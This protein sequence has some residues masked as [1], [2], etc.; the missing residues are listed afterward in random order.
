MPF[1]PGISFMNFSTS[2]NS[3]PD[4]VLTNANVIALDP[5]IPEADW[6]AIKGRKIQEIGNIN[7]NSKSGHTGY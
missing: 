7:K 4:L 5:A 1:T 2:K 6:I 3:I